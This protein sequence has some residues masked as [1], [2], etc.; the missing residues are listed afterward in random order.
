MELNSYKEKDWSTQVK[1][2]SERD[3]F[4]EKRRGPKIGMTKMMKIHYP[5]QNIK[6]SQNTN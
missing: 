2:P 6:N 4:D 5:S 1:G 3:I